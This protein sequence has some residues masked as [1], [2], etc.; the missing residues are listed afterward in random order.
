MSLL[1][2]WQDYFKVKKQD[3][4]LTIEFVLICTI[5]TTILQYVL[6]PKNLI[7][8]LLNFALNTLS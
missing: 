3:Q 7:L 6:F 2:Y 5:K 8:N 1:V 4:K